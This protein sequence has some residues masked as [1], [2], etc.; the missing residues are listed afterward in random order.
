MYTQR[1]FEDL[2]RLVNSNEAFFYVDRELDDQT[3]RIFNYRLASYTDFLEPSALECRG[4]M[5]NVTSFEDNALVD[6]TH[7]LVSFPMF[8]FFNLYENPSTMNL[9]LSTVDMIEEKADG[10]LISTFIHNNELRLKTKG[11]LDS[12]QCI[13]AMKYLEREDQLEFKNALYTIAKDGYTV[14]MEWVSPD[15]RIVLG[16]L[17]SK[18]KVLNIR[19]HLTGEYYDAFSSALFNV[20]AFDTIREN[21]VERIDLTDKDLVQFV[22]SIPDME[23]IEGYIVRLSSGLYIK[24]KTL[25]YLVQHRAKDS[26]NSDRRLFETVLAEATDDLRSLFHDDPLVIQRI[27]WMEGLVEEKYNHLVDTVERFYERNKNLERRDYA[28]LGQKELEK[29]Q[30]GLAMNKY[31]GKSVN[32]KEFMAKRWKDFG[33]KDTPE[34]DV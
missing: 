10:S 33:I 32:Y 5:F 24:I 29:M 30:F 34:N 23:G 9:D 1:L 20:P 22:E 26:I 16:Y 6:V 13:A 21:H 17:E 15:N 2:M 27:A 28:I 11:S 25:W 18:L 19:S 12:D 8:K 7:E 4:I 31:L 14:N 3:Y